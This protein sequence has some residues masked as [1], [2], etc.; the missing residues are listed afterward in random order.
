MAYEKV[1]PLF[2]P[3]TYNLAINS[4][5]SGFS[6]G[7][8][9]VDDTTVPRVALARTQSRIFLGGQA[10]EA[11]VPALK[12]LFLTRYYSQAASS[13]WEG[14]TLHY[15][16]HY[17]LGWEANIA[18]ILDGKHPMFSVRHFYSLDVDAWTRAS[19]L[20]TGYELQPVDEMLVTHSRPW[21]NLRRQNLSANYRLGLSNKWPKPGN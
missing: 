17:T 9:F 21:T 6:P 15:T 10:D 5:L 8:I 14:Y 7:H 20:L 2:A 4:I 3:L 19:L 13:D 1:R 18:K 16:L 12:Q 11:F